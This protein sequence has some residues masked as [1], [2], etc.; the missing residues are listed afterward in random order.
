MRARRTVQQPSD[1]I[2]L[3]R[4]FLVAGFTERRASQSRQ[5]RHIGCRKEF[6]NR[7]QLNFI[8]FATGPF[9]GRRQPRP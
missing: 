1:F 9:G 3:R 6:R 2:H 8:K 5:N 4:R 7:Q